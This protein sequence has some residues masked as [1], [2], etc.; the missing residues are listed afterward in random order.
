MKTSHPWDSR[1]PRKGGSVPAATSRSQSPSS[2]ASQVVRHG[3]ANAQA[4]PLAGVMLPRAR[5]AASHTV[6]FAVVALVALVGREL[7]QIDALEDAPHPP[8]C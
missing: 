3:S 8:S 5:A 2:R 4:V 6:P 1:Y 7:G